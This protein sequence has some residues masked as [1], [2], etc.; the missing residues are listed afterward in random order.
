MQLLSCLLCWRCVARGR[1]VST[2]AA[3]DSTARP[4]GTFYGAQM[5]GYR[6]CAVLGMRRKSTGTQ[7]RGFVCRICMKMRWKN[8]AT[9]GSNH[10]SHTHT[11]SLLAVRSNQRAVDRFKPLRCRSRLYV[12]SDEW[13]YSSN[14]KSS[15][16]PQNEV[17]GR[18]DR[19]R[20]VLLARVAPEPTRQRGR[21]MCHRWR[22][23]CYRGDGIVGDARDGKNWW[24]VLIAV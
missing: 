9:R 20:W 7:A 2:V 8:Q 6:L 24:K 14:R 1:E 18:D 19:F 21:L 4:G 13:A 12:C 16:L 17:N 3:G 10:P 23:E 5:D 22:I 15:H 11:L